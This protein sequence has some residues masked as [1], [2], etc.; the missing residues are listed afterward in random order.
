[1]T[2]TTPRI[3]ASLAELKEACPGASNTFLAGQLQ[4]AADVTSA[5]R[6][7]MELLSLELQA[8]DG[9]LSALKAERAS[10]QAELVALSSTSTS[11]SNAANEVWSLVDKLVAR[12]MSRR[13]AHAK[14]M[15][16]NPQLRQAFVAEMNSN[17]GALSEHLR[18]NGRGQHAAVKERPAAGLTAGSAADQVQSLVD[19]LV[20]KGMSKPEAH[21]KVMRKHPELRQAMVTEANAAR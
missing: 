1:M 12:G 20:E 14:V 21:A 17:T 8:R 13:E 10:L 6:A 2:M 4:S 19:D 11:T 5:Q 18:R 3:A 9:T 15:R 7:Y 16:D